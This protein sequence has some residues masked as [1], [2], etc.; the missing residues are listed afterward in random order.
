MASIGEMDM[1]LVALLL[2]SE[3][4]GA[5]VDE[6]PPSQLFGE[7][8]EVL[9]V[10]FSPRSKFV[11]GGAFAAVPALVQARALLASGEVRYC[12][13]GGVDSLLEGERLRALERQRR[14]KRESDPDGLIPGEAA[15]FL[16]CGPAHIGG[17]IC[18]RVAGLAGTEEARQQR[19]TPLSEALREALSEAGR[20]SSDISTVITDITGERDLAV[21]YALTLTQDFLR[22][23]RLAALLAPRQ[24]SAPSD[25]H[26]F[27]P[28]WRGCCAGRRGYAPGAHAVCLAL[29]DPGRRGAGVFSLQR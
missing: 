25:R 13:V 27:P 9:G 24:W 14:L 6:S 3:A 20:R 26:R 28:V 8:Q 11:P 15:C 7:L 29:S 1:R 5:N 19:A 23:A 12:V 16:L 22:T 4:V 18:L 2:A 10:E 21:E 17:T